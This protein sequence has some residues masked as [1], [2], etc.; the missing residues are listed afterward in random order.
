MSYAIT[1][2]DWTPEEIRVLGVLMEKA[3]TT[4]DQYPLS[5]NALMLGCN[6]STSREPVTDYDEQE[7]E[8]ALT[9]LRDRKLVY[10]VDQAG[11]RVPKFQHRLVEQWELDRPELAILTLLFLRGPQTVGQLRQRSERLYMFRDAEKV[12]ETLE[13]MANRSV[14]PIQIVVALPIQPGSKEVR[15]AHTL[16]PVSVE[17]V[18]AVSETRGGEP[19]GSNPES[20]PELR[21]RV[22]LLEQAL[23]KLQREFDAF[24]SQF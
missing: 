21:T 8:L 12:R 10:R 18:I 22:E 23:E 11:A 1:N 16:S 4:P 19:L 15:Y 13:N 7:V 14:D 6:Q 2:A 20:L 5:L 17:S 9:M 3:V 24:K